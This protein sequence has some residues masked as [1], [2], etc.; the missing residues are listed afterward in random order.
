MGQKVHPIGFRLG[1]IKNWDSI[2][3]AEGKQYV[4]NLH[5]DIA[6]RRY[7]EKK[8]SKAG[9]AKVTIERFPERINVNIHTAKPGVV[10]GKK[11]AGIDE[12]KEHIM[13][14]ISGKK[15][16]INIVGLKKPAKNA[17]IIAQTIASQLVSRVPFRRAMKQAIFNATRNGAIGIKISVAGRL[18]GAE[19][20]RKEKYM[21]GRVPLHTIRSDIDYGFAVARTT[22]GIIGIK[23]WVYNGDVIERKRGEG[24]S[25]SLLV[26]HEE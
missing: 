17:Q 6:I 20:A 10:I 13:K 5:E 9:I 8:F 21:E 23:V 15:V 7:I 12:I 24:Q 19:M 22:Y 11:G 1:I 26:E 3:Y 25:S 4:E 16:N 2:W 14:M 18:N